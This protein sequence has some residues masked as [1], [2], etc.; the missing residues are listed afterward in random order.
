MKKILI[1]AICVLLTGSTALAKWIQEPNIGAGAMAIMNGNLDTGGKMVL[2]DD[3]ECGTT[4]VVTNVHIW[5]SWKG[6]VLPEETLGDPDANGAF[7]HLSIW[8]DIAVG[9]QGNT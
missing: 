7:F 3:F 6:D 2:A 4:G 9:E 5:G 1:L 8:S